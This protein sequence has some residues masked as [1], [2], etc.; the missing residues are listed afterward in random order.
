LPY[1]EQGP[2]FSQYNIAVGAHANA[3]AT[4]VGVPVYR[5]PSDRFARNIQ[6]ANGLVFDMARGNY[7][8]NGGTSL[9]QNNNGFNNG[10]RLG[11]THFRQ[12][13]AA[14]MT[15]A[16]DGTSN[17]VCVAELLVGISAGD[18]SQGAWGYPGAAYITAY[19]D[20]G[21]VGS[22]YSITNLPPSNEIQTP[23]CDARLPTC[24]TFTPHCNNGLTGVDP[25]Y[26]CAEQNPGAA[27]RSRHTGGVNVAL[28]DGTV[29]F[30]TNS[31][32]GRVWLAAFTIIGGE[33]PG[34]W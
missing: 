25:V 26:G 27:A 23:N 32:D 5:C 20:Q 10:H 8:I 22:N 6:N 1:I 34:N 17:T 18:D 19:N 9:G 24:Q 13:F 11:L 16:Q 2:L 28:M 4:S 21:S 31:V 3:A 29:K 15:D 7:G 33:P 14:K 30:V 12:R